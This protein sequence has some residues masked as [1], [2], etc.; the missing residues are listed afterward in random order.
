M[1][2]TQASASLKRVSRANRFRRRQHAAHREVHAPRIDALDD[3]AGQ[4]ADREFRHGRRGGQQVDQR[5]HQHCARVGAG[6]DGEAPLAGRRIEV[7]GRQCGLQLVEGGVHLRPHLD[8]P[9]GR[10]H[11]G[12]SAHE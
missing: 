9:R 1:P 4:L 10:Q 12:R 7:R 8:G 5:R 6:R 11:A 2:T 3:I